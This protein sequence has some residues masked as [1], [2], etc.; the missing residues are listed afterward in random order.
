MCPSQSQTQTQ[1]S[2]MVG[3]CHNGFNPILLTVFVNYD[4]N[5]FIFPNFIISEWWLS[6]HETNENE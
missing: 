6:I 4:Q 3:E 1:A 5:F 2:F